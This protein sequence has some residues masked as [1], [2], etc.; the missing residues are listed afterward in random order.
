MPAHTAARPTFANLAR[1]MSRE[2]ALKL[3]EC[4]LSPPIE[5]PWGR[6]Y[7]LV[8]W[9]LKTDSRL[10]RRVVP[11]DCTTSQLAD[12]IKAHVPGRRYGPRDDDD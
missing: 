11:A 3:S 5:P 8:E 6:A 7:R 1:I 12:Q 2:C 4:R 10:Q 9:V